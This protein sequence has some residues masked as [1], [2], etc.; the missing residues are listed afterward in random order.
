MLRTD[1]N[2]VVNEYRNTRNIANIEDALGYKNG[3]LTGL[4]D[5]IYIFYMNN[6]KYNFDMPHGNEIGA[7]NLWISGGKTSGGYRE[8][9]IIDK[10][11]PSSGRIHDKDIENLKTQFEFTKI[12]NW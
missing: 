3:D 5:E 4:E 10:L 11:N 2:A 7:N 9:V 1:M 12:K 8:S 6:D